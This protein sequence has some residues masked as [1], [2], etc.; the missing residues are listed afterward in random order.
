MDS[1]R[2]GDREAAFEA[3][4]GSPCKT[5]SPTGEDRRD[6][7]KNTVGGRERVRTTLSGGHDYLGSV[8]LDRSHHVRP[9]HDIHNL[10]GVGPGPGGPLLSQALLH[11]IA[12]GAGNS[13]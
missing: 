13:Q 12:P 7:G 9:D 11:H 1:R 6:A 8:R 3:G 2:R 5:V 10:L 4:N